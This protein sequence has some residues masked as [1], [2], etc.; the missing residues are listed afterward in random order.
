MIQFQEWELWFQIIT[1]HSSKKF[2]K[3]ARC[4]IIIRWLWMQKR[5]NSKS[6]N[7]LESNFQFIVRYMCSIRSSH[8]KEILF[9]LWCWNWIQVERLCTLN[10]IFHLT[11]S[12]SLLFY[13][14]LH[15]IFSLSGAIKSHVVTEEEK[16]C[17]YY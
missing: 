6:G 15:I 4:S 1:A 16:F 13:E 9:D 3:V 12:V 7:K 14:L 17:S 8:S 5:S 10:S 2:N 11:S